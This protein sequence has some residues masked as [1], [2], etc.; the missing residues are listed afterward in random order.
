[1]RMSKFPKWEFPDIIKKSVLDQFILISSCVI[2]GEVYSQKPPSCQ[3]TIVRFVVRQQQD[4]SGVLC[5]RR[6]LQRFG[7][8]QFWSGLSLTTDV[9]TET[10]RPIRV[11]NQTVF[12]GCCTQTFVIPFTES[13]RLFLGN[14]KPYWVTWREACWRMILDVWVKW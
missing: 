8:G 4:G 7:P 5:S 10:Y 14:L 9:T 6:G 1:M 13:C 3:R 11:I 12:D 2:A